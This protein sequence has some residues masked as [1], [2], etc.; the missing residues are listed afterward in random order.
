LNIPLIAWLALRG[1]CK[2]CK[3]PISA[4]YIGVEL[5]TAMLFLLV[6]LTFD[7][8]ADARPFALT[9]IQNPA[10]V[11]V[12]WLVI[13]GIILGT[14]VDFEHM[15]IPD[16][17]TIGGMI[18]GLLCS[19]LVPALHDA[20]T[21]LEGLMQSAIGLAAGFGSLWAVAVLGEFA[22]KKEAMGFGD[23]KLMGAIGAF[24]GWEAVLF[25]IIIASFSGTIIGISLIL[26]NKKA[27]QSKIPFGPYLS[28]GVL[29]WMFWGP[30]L[31]SAY[32][33]LLTL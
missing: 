5:L 10:I 33:N 19:M 28:L 30:R 4:R 29:V 7:F 9:A 22:F 3:A 24:F 2:Y 21:W 31:W 26:A 12:Y 17:V 23:V 8:S 1:K 13:M 27:M 15:I 20:S 14:F 18:L 6:W 11:P 25:T 32:I 16:R